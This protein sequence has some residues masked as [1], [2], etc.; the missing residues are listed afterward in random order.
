MSQMNINTTFKNLNNKINNGVNSLLRKNENNKLYSNNNI[1]I[2]NSN[3]DLYHNNYFIDDKIDIKCLK[4]INNNISVNR[5]INSL[6]SLLTQNY[7]LNKAPLKNKEVDKSIEDLS[8]ELLDFIK[9]QFKL[10]NIPLIINNMLQSLI[11]SYTVQEKVYSFSSQLNDSKTYEKYNDKIFISKILGINPYTLRAGYNNVV[12]DEKMNI[13]GFNQ[14]NYAT[15]TNNINNN[16]YRLNPVTSNEEKSSKEENVQLPLEKVVFY[17]YNPINGQIL[18][19]SMSNILK[20]MVV[21]QRQAFNN[22]SNYLYRY[23]SPIMSVNISNTTATNINDVKEQLRALLLGKEPGITM[24]KDSQLNIHNISQAAPELFIKTIT[25]YD[26]FILRTLF[27]S[28]NS[29]QAMA[30]THSY[31][32]YKALNE[33]ESHHMLSLIMDISNV[34]NEQI[35]RHI[36]DINYDL[37]DYEYDLYPIFRIDTSFFN[38]YK[39]LILTLD[40]SYAKINNNNEWYKQIVAE[41]I[42][43]NS[44]LNVEDIEI[45]LNDYINNLIKP[46]TAN[47]KQ[48]SEPAQ[49]TARYTSNYNSTAKNNQGEENRVVNSR[50]G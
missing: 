9:L 36:I 45:E 15:F 14:D 46:D 5:G 41:F 16:Y 7:H 1:D 30:S 11:F 33:Y 8:E 12:M 29:S 50:E 6:S 39:D 32:Q 19:N 4:L 2:I 22:L 10:L 28:S 40:Q 44:S 48:D 13:I 18:G 23:S 24:D 37:S 21:N 49:D 20:P 26:Y 34:I 31:S 35:I 27:N 3:Q 43:Q 17:P 42:N 38:N 25:M 47:V